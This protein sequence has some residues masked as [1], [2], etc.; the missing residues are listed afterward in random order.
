MF[1]IRKISGLYK[2]FPVPSKLAAVILIAA[3]SAIFF[4]WLDNS[5]ELF[6]NESL[7]AVMAQELPASLFPTAHHTPQLQEGVLYP[8]AVSL[9]N[10]ITGASMEF[11]LR[12]ISLIMLI[13]TAAVAGF[14]ASARSARAGFAAGAMVLTTLL[15]IDKASEGYP[16]STNAFMLLSSQMVFFH[17]GIRKAN[18]NKA[19][20]LSALIMTCAFYSGGFRMLIFFIFPMLFFRRPLSVKS[21]FRTPGFITAVLILLFA[22]STQL[23]Q[24]T[25]TTGKSAIHELIYSNIG[26]SGYWFEL[27]A[28]IG[29][30]PIRLM[31]WTFI[32]WMP[33][34][35]ALQTIDQTPILSRY[36]RTL[37]LATFL[38]LCIL[39]G[40]DAREMIYMISPLAILTGIFYDI[41]TRRYGN[42]IRKLLITG[43]IIIL[44]VLAAFA[45]LK[46][47]PEDTI[48]SVISIS[49]TIAFRNDK[50][51]SL[52]LFTAFGCCAAC[53]VF[54]YCG[55]RNA[56]IWLLLL[57]LSVICGLFYGSVVAPYRAQE[58]RKRKLGADI[59]RVLKKEK[60]DRL[61]KFNIRD[62]YGGLFYTGKTVYQINN[63]SELPPHAEVV[64][65]I[66]TEFPQTLDRKWDNLLPSDYTYQGEHISLWKGI[67]REPAEF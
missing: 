10:R 4:P 2:E 48:G 53:G 58:K 19:W 11:S 14:S 51:Y 28:F 5:R 20:I 18:W 49:E 63:I 42:R 59:T 64:Y 43:E 24:Y 1:L 41:G 7:Y 26:D 3:V 22:V 16:T 37:V 55:R 46:F 32:A 12:T 13:L 38:A 50:L 27:L 45:A 31:P 36:L 35:V 60:A 30:L 29:M 9:F 65:V 52:V 54:F 61:Y 66:S 6:R 56:P 8:M 67:L 57:T 33:F 40:H 23:L 17:Y 34:C 47:L 62:F 15:T 44:L 25:I 39:P 21:K